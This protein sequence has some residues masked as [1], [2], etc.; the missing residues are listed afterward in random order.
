[1]RA[2]VPIASLLA[3]LLVAC[4]DGGTGADA[5]GPADPGAADA[6]DPGPA[7]DPGPDDPGGP[8]APVDAPGEASDPGTTDDPG[9]PDTP[10]D[11][12]DATALPDTP[13]DTDAPDAP[14]DAFDPTDAPAWEPA[15]AGVHPRLFFGPDDLPT[16]AAR[17]DATEGPHRTL[18]Q[19][20]RGRAA[21]ALPEHPEDGFSTA[22]SSTRGAIIEAAAFVGLVAQ[23]ADLTAKALAGL[24]AP[25]PSPHDLATGSGY[26]LHESE[27]LVAMCAAWDFLAG[28]P[29]ADAGA[30]ADARARLVQRID[31]FRTVCREGNLLYMLAFA[32]NNHVMKV[33]GALGVCAMA[34]NDRPTATRDLHEAMTGLDYLM[35]G[36]QGNADGGYAEGW[37]YLVYGA[38]SFLPF[39]VA[40]HRWADG[41]ALPYHADPLLQHGNP[42]AGTVFDIPDI[43]DQDVPRAVFRRAL[44]STRPDGRMVQTDDANPSVLHGAVAAWLFDDPGFLWQWLGDGAGLH[45]DRMDALSLALY[46]GTPRPP[47]PGL[48]LEGTACTAGFAI[49][50]ESWQPDATFLVLQ[51]EHGAMRV[52]GLGHE[53]PDEL[54]FL[55]W[56]HGQELVGD[57]GYINWANHERVYRPEDHNTILVDGKG[58]PFSAMAQQGLDVGTDAFL[59]PVVVDGDTTRVSV[60]T[61]YEGVDLARR[62]VRLGGR[63]L[64]VE[65]RL[66]ADGDAPRAYRLLLNA[67]AGGDVPDAEIT[68]LADG[69]RWRRGG[70]RIEMRTATTGGDLA[71]SSGL[72]EYAL[73]WGAWG[74]HTQLALDATMGADAGFLTALAPH[75]DGTPVPEVT[76]WRPEPGIAMVRI[77]DGADDWWAVSN[78][79]PAT[80][81]IAV[82]DAALDIPPGLTVLRRG[83]DGAVAQRHAF[84]PR[85]APCLDPEARR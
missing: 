56:A 34:V 42:R 10:R 67:M 37:N 80:R 31:D 5:A 82:G 19:R 52:N 14:A 18:A 7:P 58:A 27:A 22:V 23:D 24:A 40:Y 83:A 15:L 28:N 39:W 35:N 41:R 57:A 26:D 17:M 70:A 79:T 54:S 76:A 4:A 48:P 21:Q 51:G 68:L 12:D 62:I 49:L 63:F 77:V 2:A 30:L 46:D 20:L 11:A 6:T 8:D 73:Q 32:R 47:D 59:T 81:P 66:A 60:A 85:E 16:L 43:P 69:A 33:F 50:R 3:V 84:P 53:H 44:W 38:N 72:Q 75:A 13:D 64:V 25:Y 71:V 74:W 1:M 29:L 36:F 9:A 45:S 65:D 78:R 55:L 61:R